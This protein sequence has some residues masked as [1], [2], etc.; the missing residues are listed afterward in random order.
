MKMDRG[1]KERGGWKKGGRSDRK[2]EVQSERSRE[3]EGNGKRKRE[4]SKEKNFSRKIL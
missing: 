1:L 4:M 2:K 3:K